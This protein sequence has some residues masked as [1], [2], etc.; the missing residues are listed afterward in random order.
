MKIKEKIE[1]QQ[2]DEK[3]SLIDIPQPKKIKVDYS[4]VHFRG[5]FATEDIESEEIIERCPMV[6]LDHRIKYHKDPQLFKY[7]YT[8]KCECEECKNHGAI[9]LM[10]LGYGMIY[11]H[12]DTPNTMWVFNYEKGVAD[13]VAIMPIKKGDEIFVSYGDEYFKGREKISLNEDNEIESKNI[14][15][16]WFKWV[17][18]NIQRGVYKNKIKEILLSNKFEEKQIKEMLK[19]GNKKNERKG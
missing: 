14:P 9:F 6:P 19:G 3:P 4:K 12:Q 10:V 8:H 11:N 1:T 7:L 5:V 18:E 17:S 13:V 15:E 2:K 16:E